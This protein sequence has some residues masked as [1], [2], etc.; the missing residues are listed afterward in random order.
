MAY[1]FLGS[2][3]D[4]TAFSKKNLHRLYTELFEFFRFCTILYFLNSAQVLLF[5][6][7]L[8]FVRIRETSPMQ[9]ELQF[10]H[11][12]LDAIA[13]DLVLIKTN[14]QISGSTSPPLSVRQAAAYL[15]LSESRVYDLVYASKLQPLQNQKHGRILFS[16]ET[17]NKYLHEK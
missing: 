2:V 5:K 10:I 11:Q 6:T 17:L 8:A 3:S 14:M 12:K 9:E 16:T 13:A 7:G 1:L 4:K 15:H